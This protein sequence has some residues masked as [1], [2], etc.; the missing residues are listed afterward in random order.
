MAFLTPDG[1]TNAGGLT[2]NEYLLSKHNPNSID[3]PTTTME[4]IGVTIHNTDWISVAS[5]TTPA[6]QYTRATVNGNMGT[7]RVHYY[8]D[9]VCAWQCLP[10]NRSGWHAADGNGNGNRKTIAIECIMENS[11]DAKSLQSE[12]NAAKLT[13]YL[14]HRYGWTVEKNLYTH[15]YWLHVRDG[16]TGTVADLNTR[17]HSYKVCPAYITPHWSSFVAKVSKYLNELS[18][19]T[20]SS[21]TA[22]ASTPYLVKVTASDG[23][24]NVRKTPK[25]S[26]SDIVSTI[27][28]GNT[29]YTIVAEK[30]VDGVTFGKLKSGAGWVALSCCTKVV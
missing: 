28:S 30:V 21:T 4:P 10:L 6:E 8:V 14:L 3:M 29:L 7:V 19:T 11:T 2:V 9:N 27:K 22:A 18:G 20:T 1:T 15:T 24:V 23:F 26:D 25:F 16:H 5:G 12:D 17:K 13:A